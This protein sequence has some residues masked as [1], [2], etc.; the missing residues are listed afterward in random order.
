MSEPNPDLW[1][2]ELTKLLAAAAALSVEH[3]IDGDAFVRDA[4]SAYLEARPGMRE[5]LEDMQLRARLEQLR[6]SGLVPTA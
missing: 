5:Q 2:L 3:D 4:W 6:K 1:K